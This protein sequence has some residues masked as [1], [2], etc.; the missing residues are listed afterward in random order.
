MEKR[1]QGKTKIKCPKYEFLKKK[2]LKNR[3]KAMLKMKLN[4]IIGAGPS[5]IVLPLCLMKLNTIP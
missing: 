3:V 1:I 5:E 4:F 2:E